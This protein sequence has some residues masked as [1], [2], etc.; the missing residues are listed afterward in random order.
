MQKLYLTKKIKKID[1]MQNEINIINNMINHYQSQAQ[2]KIESLFEKYGI[3]IDDF[4]KYIKIKKINDNQYNTENDTSDETTDEPED[5]PIDEPKDEYEIL[6]QSLYK[7]LALKTH[8]DKQNDIKNNDFVIINKFYE[9]RDL[10]SLIIYS[11]KYDITDCDMESMDINLV[12]IIVEIKLNKLIK[13]LEAVKSQ[14][15]YKILVGQDVSKYMEAYV[16]IIDYN[17]KNE[18][19]KKENWKIKNLMGGIMDDSV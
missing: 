18:N 19:L 4:N 6:S 5:E 15:G 1:E 10:Y 12:A 17:K 8:P 3:D 11:N 9:E 16:Q 7:K 13:E 14:F 2:K